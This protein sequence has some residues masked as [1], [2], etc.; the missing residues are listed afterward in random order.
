LSP[1]RHVPSPKAGT[2]SPDGNLTF[3]INNVQL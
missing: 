1:M 3:F 2:S